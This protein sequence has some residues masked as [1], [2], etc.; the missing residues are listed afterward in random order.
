MWSIVPRPSAG[1]WTRESSVRSGVAPAGRLFHAVAAAVASLLGAAAASAANPPPGEEFGWF[2]SAAL[3]GDDNV[4]RVPDQQP[5]GIELAP[6]RSDVSLVS[7]AGI[8]FDVPISAQRVVGQFTFGDH[9]YNRFDE[10]DHDSYSGRVGLLWQVGSQIEGQ[11]LLRQ[12][13]AM[14]S[15]ANL[16]NLTQSSTRN[17]LRTR[18]ALAEARYGLLSAWQL[19]GA[20]SRLE[21]DNSSD[22]FRLSDLQ[23]DAVEGELTYVTPAEN[24]LGVLGRVEEGRLLNRQ[25]INGVSISNSYWQNRIVGVMDWTV[26]EKSRLS[27]RGGRVEREYKMFPQRDYSGLTYNAG[28]EWRPRDN[29]SLSAILRR[30]ISDSEQ[31][32]VGLVVMRTVLFQPAL[33]LNQKTRLSLNL[34]EGRRTYHGNVISA[35]GDVAPALTEHVRIIQ[36]ALSYQATPKVRLTLDAR[37][38]QRD[39]ALEFQD[40]VAK[41]ANFEIRIGL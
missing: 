4:F 28:Y 17:L 31:V 39:S 18:E 32:D 13:R 27:L 15:L 36:A 23:R 38:E 5:P 41:I 20:V 19:R 6:Q 11:V 24:R 37:R 2:A 25:L 33:Q 14:T 35:V 26:T 30:D 29:L 8:H 16:Q 22:L 34:E 10:L 3:T 7:S 12:E 40:Y 9:R 21:H 1:R